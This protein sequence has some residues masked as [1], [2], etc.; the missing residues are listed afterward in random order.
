MH[1]YYCYYSGV[2]LRRRWQRRWQMRKH[3][4]VARGA[5]RGGENRRRRIKR[6]FKIRNILLY[7]Y[8]S[9]CDETRAFT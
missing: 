7:R 6:S 2:S 5:G 8:V 9:Q 1:Y 3:T 4:F